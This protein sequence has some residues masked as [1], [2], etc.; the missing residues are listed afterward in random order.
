MITVALETR[1]CTS[2]E[3]PE[4]NN[5]EQAVEQMWGMPV[6]YQSMKTGSNS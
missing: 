4:Q 2:Q 3:Q 6:I 1:T 5:T